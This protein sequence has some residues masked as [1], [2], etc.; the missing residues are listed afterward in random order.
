MNDLIKQRE[1]IEKCLGEEIDLETFLYLK[2][3]LFSNGKTFF[4]FM[5]EDSPPAVSISNGAME[6]VPGVKTSQFGKVRV[7]HVD[8]DIYHKSIRGKGRYDRFMK[9]LNDGPIHDDVQ[10]YAKDNPNESIMLCDDRTGSLSYLKTGKSGA[11][12]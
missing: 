6:Q 2:S 8:S 3:E 7:Y 10:Q 9:Y 4:Q 1:F 11:W 5:E 12:C